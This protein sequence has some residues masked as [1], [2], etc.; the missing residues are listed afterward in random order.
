MIEFFLDWGW[1]TGLKSSI[2]GYFE[3]E[4][5]VVEYHNTLTFSPLPQHTVEFEGHIITVE[6]RDYKD[7]DIFSVQPA[8]GWIVE[9]GSNPAYVEEGTTGTLVLCQVSLS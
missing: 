7:P 2:K 1:E 6:L 5:L 3:K 8:H 4:C 9:S